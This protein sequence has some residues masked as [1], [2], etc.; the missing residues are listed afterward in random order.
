MSTRRKPPDDPGP[1]A[2]RD[3]VL[4]LLSWAA[5]DGSVIAM[6]TL[7]EELRREGIE[8]P[9]AASIIDEIAKRRGV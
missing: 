5:R 1:T 3:E 4:R 6:K 9:K 2:D 8:E 7:L